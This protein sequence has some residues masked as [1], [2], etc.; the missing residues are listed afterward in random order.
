MSIF[1]T[2]TGTCTGPEE[3]ECDKGCSSSGSDGHCQIGPQS[4]TVV[5]EE[6]LGASSGLSSE[7]GSAEFDTSS[8]YQAT[9]GSCRVEPLVEGQC[10]ESARASI[11]TIA[12]ATLIPHR[13]CGHNLGTGINATNGG[14]VVHGGESAGGSTGGDVVAQVSEKV[15]VSSWSSKQSCEMMED[16]VISEADWLDVTN[17]MLHTTHTSDEAGLV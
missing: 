13:L 9:R 2:P 17:A 11:S 5:P 3:N 14:G 7:S 4:V 1:S 15:L 10:M 16:N 12:A 8:T 6:T